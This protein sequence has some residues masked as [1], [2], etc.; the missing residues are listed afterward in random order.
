M[1]FRDYP[2]SHKNF[3]F[4][5]TNILEWREEENEYDLVISISTV[6]HVG[7][8]GYG[9]P[10]NNQGDKIAV[11]KLFSAAKQ[12][13]KLIF[14]VP[15]GEPRTARNMRIYNKKLLHELIPNIEKEMYFVKDG[16][17]GDWYQTSASVAERKNT[18]DFNKIGP[19]ESLA[20]VV[21]RKK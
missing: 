4:K 13:A 9:A 11:N 19:S 5:Q 15:F 8:G 3:T 6:E 18:G 21:A 1:D 17:Y 20:F 10:E 14:T 2:L 16:R 12:G 7:L